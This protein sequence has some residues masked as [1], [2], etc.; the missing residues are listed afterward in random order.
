MITNEKNVHPLSF[1][2][3]REVLNAMVS[4]SDKKDIKEIANEA[5]RQIAHFLGVR[6][7]VISWWDKEKNTLK[8]WAKYF[9]SAKE[10]NPKW[11]KT[12][13]IEDY[14]N[15]QQVLS[16][17]EPLQ[18]TT[19]EIIVDEEDDKLI[20]LFGAKSLL[21]LPL[22]SEKEIIGLAGVLDPSRVRIFSENE[23]ALVSLLLKYIGIL[24][25][26]AELLK[27]A[28]QRTAELSAISEVSL[29]LT[30][31]QSYDDV[32]NVI[33][34]STLNL[35]QDAMDV[36]IFMYEKGKL[37]FGA[38]MWAD[39]NIS[40]SMADPR[41]DG[42][43]YQVAR[44]AKIR[45]VE[46]IS[47]DPLF[48]ENPKNWKGA[49]IGLPLINQ[50]RVVGVMNIAFYKS[51]QFDEDVLKVLGMLGGQVAVAIERSHN[52]DLIKKRASELE[53]L[54]EVNLILTASLDLD[55]VLSAVL[56]SALKFSDEAMDAHIFLY[57]G[58]KLTFGGA[59]WADGTRKTKWKDPRENGIT[60]SVARKGEIIAV[61]DFFDHE[62][63][64][65]KVE[66]GEGGLA[67]VVGLPIIA[68]GNVIGVMNLAYHTPQEFSEDDLRSLG[69]L[70]DQAALAIENARLHKIVSKQAVTDALTGL[71]NRRAF[72][73]Q[74]KKEVSRAKRYKRSLILVMMDLNDFKWVNDNFG[75]PVGDKTL[76]MVGDCLISNIRETDFVARL[77]GD[78]FGMILPETDI[79]NAEQVTN[80]LSRE[81]LACPYHWLTN[82]QETF[83]LGIGI[84]IASYPEDAETVEELILIADKNLYK[85]KKERIK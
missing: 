78:E 66:W 79:I 10:L 63:F 33:L 71:P 37:N 73:T 35:F 39:G 9:A 16:A 1:Q 45:V 62:L 46:D 30:S 48:K 54:R 17:G 3:M 53:A 28:N 68:K 4:I 29:G 57:D 82:S 15:I 21:L 24:I 59:L 14:P 6:T 64:S 32:L 67:S 83:K 19:D 69:L 13:F 18:I 51:R 36:H 42:L 47:T 22:I 80:K 76:I 34:K 75:H 8:L 61:S 38:A 12:Y 60:Y 31:N 20:R 65:D 25:S 40:G 52:I 41:E 23:I 2:H 72:E 7:V 49:I 55:E 27:N 5:C 84:G 43:T 77:G 26:Q 50:N 85:Y 81:I 58:E 56:N 44:Q 70:A 74:F 11:L